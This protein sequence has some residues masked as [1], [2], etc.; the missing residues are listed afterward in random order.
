MKEKETK[1]LALEKAQIEPL[2]E[3]YRPHT[4][5]TPDE[6]N[7]LGTGK[8]ANIDGQKGAERG[9]PR[10]KRQQRLAKS[11]H[12][13]TRVIKPIKAIWIHCWVI[14]WL[15]PKYIHI[16]PKKKGKKV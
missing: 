2:I 10:N 3:K 6:V 13:K 12:P 8:N 16:R 14:L 15:I 9:K 7:T 5:R 1:R 4:P 11:K